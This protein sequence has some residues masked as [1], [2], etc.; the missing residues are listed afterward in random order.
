MPNTIG[1]VAQNMVF[2]FQSVHYVLFIFRNK[3]CILFFKKKY[4]IEIRKAR[5]AKL[6]MVHQSYNSLDSNVLHHLDSLHH[7]NICP[8]DCGVD[9]FEGKHGYC[10]ADAGFNIS[11]ICIHRGEEPAISGK[12][13]IVNIF[14]SH[15][16]LQCVFCQNFQISQNKVSDVPHLKT[17]HDIINQICVLLDTGCQSVGFV[18]PSHYVQ[19]VKVIIDALRSVGRK[20]IFVYNT[21]GYDKVEQLKT[22][23]GYIDV[24]LP[25]FKYLDTE[26]SLKYS[27]SKNYPDYIKSAIKEMYRQKGSTLITDENSVAESGLIIRHLVLPGHTQDSLNILE[28]IAN[29]I[30]TNVHL[31]IMS[32]YYPTHKVSKYE[33]L[34]RNI[35]IDEYNQVVNKFNELGFY[36]GWIQ[37]MESNANYRPDFEY[38]HPFEH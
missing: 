15:C 27:G 38:K 31:S 14:F 1:S 24:Y 10:N 21:N 26:L 13:G 34:N 8:R 4:E 18:S 2:W 36:K 20:P 29:E 3:Y 35:S 6:K 25:D 33:N 12:N 16:N 7:C 5:F 22:L 28:W 32:Q 19:H 30:S 37:E 17:L 11:S 9:R 23:E